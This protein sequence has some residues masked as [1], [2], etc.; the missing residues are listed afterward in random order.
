MVTYDEAKRQANIK[1]H[2]IDLAETSAVFDF[3]ILTWEDDRMAYGEA[4]FGSLGLLSGRVVLLIW[5][6][7]ETGPH[8]IS[9]RYGGKRDVKRYY[10]NAF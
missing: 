5:T 2:G 9:C 8:V 4:R 6:E 3:P 1:K 10:E 7:R